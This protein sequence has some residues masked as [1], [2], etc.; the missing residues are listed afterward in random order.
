MGA[1]VNHSNF[2]KRCGKGVCFF[3]NL[4]ISPRYNSAQKS[5]VLSCDF[6][7]FF[8]SMILSFLRQITDDKSVRNIIQ[9]S[10]MP[11]IFL[12]S[13]SHLALYPVMKSHLDDSMVF[14]VDYSCR[15]SLPLISVSTSERFY[16]QTTYLTLRHA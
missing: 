16:Q 7:L 5:I 12:N 11:L 8:S 1:Q 3:R 13:V 4:K 15:Q 14:P 6:L 9:L 10:H 2:I